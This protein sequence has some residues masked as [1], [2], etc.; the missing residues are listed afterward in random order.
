M[1]LKKENWREQLEDM[2]ARKTQLE[3]TLNK[4]G[5]EIVEIEES[6]KEEKR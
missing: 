2:A 4:L 3:S 6:E 5:Q 1:A